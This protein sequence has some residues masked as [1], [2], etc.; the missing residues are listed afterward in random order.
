MTKRI[1]V[2][3]GVFTLLGVG[4]LVAARSAPQQMPRDRTATQQKAGDRAVFDGKVAELERTAAQQPGNAQAQHVV[5]TFYYEKT[6]DQSLGAEE[7]RVYLQRGLAA[8]NRA[9]AADPDY[10][11][12]LVYKNILLVRRR[13]PRPTPPCARI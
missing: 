10:V 7:K 13:W 8:E 4:G 11:E 12:A 3:V 2:A 9:L 5:A 6:R 1:A